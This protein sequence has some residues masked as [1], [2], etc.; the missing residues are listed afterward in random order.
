LKSGCQLVSGLRCLFARGLAVKSKH[1]ICV[2]AVLS[3]SER[4]YTD[5]DDDDDD[6][7]DSDDDVI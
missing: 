7:D 1:V 6:D 2:F 3:P 5:D 4:C